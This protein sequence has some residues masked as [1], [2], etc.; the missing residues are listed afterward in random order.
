MRIK[1]IV[2]FTRC[3]HWPGDEPANAIAMSFGWKPSEAL[4]PTPTCT[5][6]FIRMKAE[7]CGEPIDMPERN[8]PNTLVI[9]FGVI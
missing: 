7:S 1:F 4:C 8:S 6:I 3:T 5:L 2:I 9:I